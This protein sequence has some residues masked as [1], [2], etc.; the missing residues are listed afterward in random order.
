M[1]QTGNRNRVQQLLIPA[2]IRLNGDR[3]WDIRVNDDRFFSRLLSGGSMAAGESYMAG[4]WDCPALDQF[5]DRVLRARI[6]KQL[7]SWR[8]LWAIL[9]ARL[10]NY[11]KTSRAFLIGRHYDTGNQLFSRMLDRRMI[12]SCGYWEKASNLDEAQETKLELVCRKLQLQ[13]GMRL[14]DIGCG[15]GGTARYAAE[16]YGVEVVGIT[17]SGEQAE[18]AKT[19][20]RGLPVEIRLQDYR[21]LNEKFDRIVSI[22]MF[23][24]VGYQ[25][26]RPFMQIVRKNLKSD[27]LFL[28]HT[29][30][31]NCSVSRCDPWIEHYIFPNSM[32]PSAKQIATAMEGLF[33]LED[34]H[35]FGQDYDRTLMAWHDNFEK[36]WPDLRHDYDEPFY[37]M[38]RYYLLLCAGAFRARSNQ[39]W[40][41][42]LSPQGV[43]G[44]YRRPV[45]GD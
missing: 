32:L 6:D 2:D 31:G 15:W 24:H 17:V 4:W 21:E 41:L 3:P 14:L 12:Y 36:A 7:L 44:G 39:L 11:Q 13:P 20:C 34:W 40:Q 43:R 9:I 10:F 45:I 33:V 35:C 29:I 18:V 38:W 42:L 25:N 28:L 8:W 27:G 1:W 37:R 19:L 16:R 22:G 26:Y 5:F 23:E 30:G